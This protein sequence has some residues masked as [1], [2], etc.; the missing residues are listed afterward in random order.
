MS[1]EFQRWMSNLLARLS[2]PPRVDH[3]HNAAEAWRQRLMQEASQ[4]L[5]AELAPA[6]LIEL[7]RDGNG[8]VREGALRALGEHHSLEAL[9]AIVE[10]LN[11]WVPVVRRAALQAFEAYL[12]LAHAHL[13]LR[14]L[15]DV[16]QLQ[17]RHRDDHAAL[18]QRVAAVLGQDALRDQACEAL[19]QLRSRA[20]RFLFLALCAADEQGRCGLVAKAMCHVDLTVR[21]L[22]L[23][24]L[25]ELPDETAVPLLVTACR[26]SVPALR[27][28]ALG[29]LLSKPIA[30][31][32]R[33]Q[34]VERGVVD[35]SA[36]VRDLARWYAG[37]YQ[38]DLSPL[39][40]R[41][42][43]QPH[44]LASDTIALLE[45]SVTTGM[46]DVALFKA[47]MDHPL[48]SVR[49]AGLAGLVKLTPQSAASAIRRA[50]LDPSAK[51]FRMA[52]DM[53]SDP[54]VGVTTE[55]L[56]SVYLAAQSQQA[57]QR[58]VAVATLLPLWPQ[59]DAL[60]QCYGAAPSAYCLDALRKWESRQAKVYWVKPANADSVRIH[61]RWNA[62]QGNRQAPELPKLEFALR[63]YG[64]VD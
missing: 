46:A 47:A 7:S 42:E 13:L 49:R 22:A 55:D 64:L 24:Q 28:R 5:A 11:D 15:D 41:L 21:S 29:T 3:P 20:G 37:K 39:R 35:R 50:L 40:N 18:L 6:R 10:R 25:A 54:G 38:I 12:E 60:L 27:S 45:L 43:S 32:E 30:N 57:I 19:L 23:Q 36:G 1:F 52:S 48:A 33:R 62:L 31:D 51:V 17:T 16:V 56:L 8:F 61:E 53:V 34:W 9:Q 63:Q 4:L 14:C 59:L 44:R 58:A 2:K 26:D